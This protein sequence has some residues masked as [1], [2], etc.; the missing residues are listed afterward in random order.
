MPRLE[1]PAEF[2][3]LVLLAVLRLGDAAY[4]VRSRTRD[5]GARD[6]PARGAVY[7]TLAVGKALPRVWLGERWRG[8]GGRAR[9]YR[10]RPAAARA[11]ESWAARGARRARAPGAHMTPKL[12]R[13]FLPTALCRNAIGDLEEERE[14]SA[15]DGAGSG[16][17][18]SG[19]RSATRG[20]SGRG[21]SGGGPTT[22]GEEM[23]SWKRC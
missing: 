8:R 7:A 23:D 16:P 22:T 15:R 5:P 21:P 1:P 10:V 4:A 14:H 13:R 11:R 18:R 3:Q 9:R 2:E 19:S 12:L 6:A 20:I 17:A